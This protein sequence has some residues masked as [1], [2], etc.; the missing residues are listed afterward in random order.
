[1]IHE[2]Q[3]QFPNATITHNGNSVWIGGIL[4]GDDLRLISTNAQ[5]LQ[6]MIHVCQTWSE[7]VRMQINANKSKI[8]AFHET[9]QQKN[10]R[11]KPIKK[12]GQNLY[13]DP[14]HLLS[15]F[16]SKRSQQR[17]DV[18][19]KTLGSLASAGVKCTPLQEVKEFDYLGLRLDPKLTMK[20]ASNA[21]KV[22]AMKGHTLVSAVSY[23]LC[24]NKHHS[25][26]TCA[27]SNTKVINLWK[28]CVLPH[29]LLYLSYIHSDSQIQKLQVC[30]N[31]S[32]SSMLHVYGHATALLAEV[33]IP[34]FHI[35][36][37]L[38]LAQLR[39]RLSTNQNNIIP[40]T[41]ALG[42]TLLELHYVLQV[43]CVRQE[44]GG[45]VNQGS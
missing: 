13:P 4:Y 1:L 35:T 32:H 34:P 27:E 41:L 17:R 7:K 9:A 26:P 2:L 28:S 5:E 10:A 42:M 36:Q 14:F 31:R 24:Y 21:I 45:G 43:F 8:M 44:D 15:S 30:L 16:P 25:N 33:G 12:G 3:R 11:Q 22:K 23:S 38:Q 18:D 20:A 29:F 40:H 39:Y 37:N 6:E 19:E